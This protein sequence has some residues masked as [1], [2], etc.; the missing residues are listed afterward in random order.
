MRWIV[1]LM[2]LFAASEASAQQ[3]CGGDTGRP[4]G[5][6]AC[7]SI[8]VLDR[9]DEAAKPWSQRL[10]AWIVDKAKI[11][12]GK[13]VDR[14]ATP[15]SGGAKTPLLGGGQSS[16]TK[17]VEVVLLRTGEKIGTVATAGANKP[18]SVPDPFLRTRPPVPPAPLRLQAPALLLKK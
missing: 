18:K 12:T 16:S 4:G 6:R 14:T 7:T 17:P 1:F 9:L 5:G 10:S 8:V 3:S 2:F 13:A 15:T 11:N